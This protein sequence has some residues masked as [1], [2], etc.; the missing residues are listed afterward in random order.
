MASSSQSE[1]FSQH[2]IY[3]LKVS[4][5][6]G[7]LSMFATLIM[8][9]LN[10]IENAEL[11]IAVT[12]EAGAGKSTFI[13]AMRGLRGCDEGAAEIGN[14]ETTMEQTPYKHSTFPNVC[15]WDLPGVE[16]T[17]F[18]MKD[19]VS[20]MGLT[21][22]DFF[23]IISQNRFTE[24]D[25]KVAKEIQNL[26]KKFY[27][28]RSQI[29]NDF[30]SLEMQGIDFDRMR[31][32]EEMKQNISC[33]LTEVGISNPIIFQI[34]C[35]PPANSN[36]DEFK[37]TLL[38]N[39]NGIKK[40][41]LLM[42]LQSTTVKIVE[43]KQAQLKERIWMLA[44]VSGVLGVVSVPGLYFAVDLVIL[45][46]AIIDFR[47]SLGLD[48][49][50][51]QRLANVAK[52]PVE[53][54]KAEVRSPLMGEINAEFVK[55]MLWRSSIVA[56]SMVEVALNMIPI[57][58]SIFGSVSSLK[59][60]YKLLTDVLDELVENAQRMVKVAFATDPSHPQ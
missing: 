43:M 37:Q 4:Y 21:T 27:F 24:N 14:I 50:S 58:G 46:T 30:S 20:R 48:D 25:A 44:T 18:P 35:L 22:Y 2:E 11:N 9:K 51:L 60:T 52:K 53:F 57:I 38:D 33:G 8:K 5:E 45:V 54:L 13:N 31:K 32:L 3:Q 36:L 47:K 42:S 39:L 1:Y 41:V 10:D 17:K 15:F 34:S 28:V 55:Q 29:D 12:G 23:I 26:G 59:M 49:A 19:Y 6:Q 7:G 16:T 56:V 40:D